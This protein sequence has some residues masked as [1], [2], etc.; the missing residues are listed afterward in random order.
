MLFDGFDW[1]AGNSP[2]CGKHGVSRAEI[3]FVLSNEPDVLPDRAAAEPEIRFNA[4]GA[5]REGRHVFIVFNFRLRKGARL[6]RPISARYMHRK[7][8][9]RYERRRTS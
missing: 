3:E 1:D 6:L 8:V 2:K 7:E 9:A 5:N 4:V